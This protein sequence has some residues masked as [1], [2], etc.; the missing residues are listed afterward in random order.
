MLGAVAMTVAI[1]AP[2][3]LWGLIAERLHLR[4]FPVGY[5]VWPAERGAGSGSARLRLPRL[6][7]RR[8]GAASR[9]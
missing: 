2:R 7:L 9:P 4:L 6:R 5:W 8:G 3:G 1:W